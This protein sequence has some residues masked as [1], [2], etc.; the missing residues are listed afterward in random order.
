MLFAFFSG[1]KV[2]GNVREECP[3]GNVLDPKA[4]NTCPWGIIYTKLVLT[5]TGRPF[6]LDVKLVCSICCVISTILLPIKRKYNTT[7]ISLFISQ[8]SSLSACL[9]VCCLFVCSLPS[10][11]ILWKTGWRQSP[12][13]F[14]HSYGDLRGRGQGWGSAVWRLPETFPRPEAVRR[15]SAPRSFLF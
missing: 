13:P 9:Q 5:F 10:E 15:R 12:L 7:S 8:S 2:R 14:R 6:I 11:C 4:S 3:G 1:G